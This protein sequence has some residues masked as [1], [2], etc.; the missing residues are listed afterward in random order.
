M[1]IYI[2]TYTH[3]HTHTHIHTYIHT[4]THSDLRRPSTA[5]ATSSRGASHPA[6]PNL[7]I[8][9]DGDDGNAV[10]DLKLEKFRQARSHIK[11]DGGNVSP[12]ASPMKP[13]QPP[14]V[15]PLPPP[16]PSGEGKAG[17]PGECVS[18]LLVTCTTSNAPPLLSFPQ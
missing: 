10:R 11:G 7:T 12:A 5:S 14:N 13:L 18:S 6:A 15:P 4:Y 16:V 17:V 2:Y 3:T 1:Y 9:I 8:Q